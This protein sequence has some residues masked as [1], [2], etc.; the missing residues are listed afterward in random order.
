[1]IHGNVMGI[2]SHL[3]ET[4]SLELSREGAVC[5]SLSFTESRHAERLCIGCYQ[6]QERCRAVYCRAQLIRVTA[7]PS[8]LLSSNNHSLPRIPHKLS[9]RNQDTHIIPE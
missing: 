1:M 7:E 5:E 3:L 4:F 9:R 8:T 6:E 2:D